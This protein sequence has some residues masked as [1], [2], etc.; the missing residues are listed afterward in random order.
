ML[1]VQKYP[2]LLI[3]FLFF[4][5]L[6]FVEPDQAPLSLTLPLLFYLKQIA[7][8]LRR[9]HEMIMKDD[10]NN[11]NTANAEAPQCRVLVFSTLG[12]GLFDLALNVR[13]ENYS[14]S[15][16]NLGQ[17]PVHCILR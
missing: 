12:I 7:A 3:P 10:H 5:C 2:T 17:P 11:V 16:F 6:L 8:M 14:Q 15:I 9:D 4:D 13:L 1:G